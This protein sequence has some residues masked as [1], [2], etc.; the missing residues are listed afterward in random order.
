M[1]KSVEQ[2]MFYEERQHTKQGGSKSIR[3]ASSKPTMSKPGF[4]TRTAARDGKPGS[5]KK[6][7]YQMP[8]RSSRDGKQAGP[9][10]KPVECFLCKQKGHYSNE[11]LKKASGKRSA[12]AEKAE[13]EK[14]EEAL[15]NAAEEAQSGSEE[16]EFFS[17]GEEGESRD[18]EEEDRASTSNE[19]GL[20]LEDWT[21]AIRG[22]VGSDE[23]NN[24]SED[25]DNHVVYRGEPHTHRGAGLLDW[26]QMEGTSYPPERSGN[27]D[28]ASYADGLEQYCL[29]TYLAEDEMMAWSLKINEQPGEQVAYRQQA[30]KDLGPFKIGNGPK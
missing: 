22:I 15:V 27:E 29:A 18:E 4:K 6:K 17:K 11:C 3:E 24:A 26:S 13:D 12:N 1:A 30:T 7:D 25:E 9:S 8:A 20:S 14:A 28:K 2:G 5:F 21:C 23:D 10:T 16:E 19:D